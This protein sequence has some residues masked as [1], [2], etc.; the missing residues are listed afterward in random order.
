MSYKSL[1]APTKYFQGKGLMNDIYERTC[2][3]GKKY[4]FL[5]DEVV[6]EIVRDKIQKA[7]EGKDGEY[8][9]I[10]HGGE[11]TL[12]EALRIATILTENNC[13][14]IVGVGGG[15]V[16]DSAKLAGMQM[17]GV[18]TV[19]VPT[20]AASDAPCS[21]NT[22]IYDSEGTFLR[23]EKPK[24]NPSVVLVDTEIIANAPARLL[25]AGMGDAFVTYYEARASKRAGLTNLSGGQCTQ[26]GFAIAKLCRDVL[27]EHGAKAKEDV[28]KKQWSEEVEY[29]TEANIYLS[30]VGFENNGVSVSHATYNGLTGV[31]TPFPVLHGEGVAFG[32]LVQLILEYTEAGKWD[33]EEWNL[34]I[35]FFKSVGLPTK[36]NQIQISNP[37]DELIYRIAVSICNGANAHREPFEVNPEKVAAALRCI[38][39]MD[40]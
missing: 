6:Y 34:V 12:A 35:E 14:V 31:L 37:T 9:Y 40:I 17:D 5:V 32:L 3:L 11:S 1:I 23:A 13:D 18:K 15:K 33:D 29:V 22:V 2:H 26:A 39:E 27:L 21:A 24:E 16:I 28:E 8:I 30:G 19:I 38:R 20:S 10:F 4:A 7:F 25:V 36:F